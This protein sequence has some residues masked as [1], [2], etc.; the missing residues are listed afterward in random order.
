MLRI[1]DN[2]IESKNGQFHAAWCLV[3]EDGRRY[4]RVA[5]LRERLERAQAE[6]AQ[7]R[8]TREELQKR[9]EEAQQAK[10]KPKKKKGEAKRQ[11]ERILTPEELPQLWRKLVEE[12]SGMIFFPPA[13]E[14]FKA[15]L[16]PKE[17]D[18]R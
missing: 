10:E 2:G 7:E 12:M 15:Q 16:K 17:S 1:L 14:H 9:L 4:Y 18:I 13:Q 6:A 5:V 8:R 11:P 3:D